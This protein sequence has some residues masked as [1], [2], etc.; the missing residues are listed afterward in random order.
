M[1]LMD[2]LIAISIPNIKIIQS[3]AIVGQKKGVK[4]YIINEK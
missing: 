2:K 3:I 4:D 1:P